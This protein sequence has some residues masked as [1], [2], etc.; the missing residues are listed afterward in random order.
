MVKITSLINTTPDGFVDAQYA[1]IDAAYFEFVH[2][3]LA[4]TGS[5]AFGRRSF[6]QFQSVWTARLDDQATPPW[7][8]KMAQALA[9]KPKTV[10]SSSLASVQWR[11][12]SIAREINP[13]QLSALKDQSNGGVLTL[14]SLNLVAGLAN[15]NMIDEYYFCV[16]PMLAGNGSVR[17]FEAIRL[18]EQQALQYVDSTSLSSGVHIIHYRRSN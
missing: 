17:L 18:P 9:E 1:K 3:I 7:Q 16:Q 10:Y 13:A 14:A 4:H 15:M 12:T 2:G 5:I 8:L 6:E 11:N